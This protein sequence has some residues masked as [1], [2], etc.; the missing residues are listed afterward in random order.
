MLAGRGKILI[1]RMKA[2]KWQ[3]CRLAWSKPFIIFRYLRPC[4]R[5]VVSAPPRMTV[6][7]GELYEALVEV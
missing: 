7:A 6:N 1:M 2:V 3:T 4:S 5:N